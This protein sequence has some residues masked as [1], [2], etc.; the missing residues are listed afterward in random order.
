ME[1]T[2]VYELRKLESKDIFP[3]FR[4]ISKIGI[5]EFKKCFSNDEIK[6]L[7]ASKGEVEFDKLA[8]IVGVSVGF[9]IAS[10]IVTNIPKCENEIYDFLASI[11]DLKRKELEKLPMN[12]FLEMIID[13]IKK[14]EFK[15]FFGVVSKLFK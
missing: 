6:D 8:S 5:D 14:E 15:D 4:I 12:I 11:S 9:D 10:I 7:I 2:K 13:L 3:M 1:E